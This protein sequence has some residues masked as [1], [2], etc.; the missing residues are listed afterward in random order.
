M[1]IEYREES[2]MNVNRQHTFVKF[3]TT[4]YNKELQSFIN[5][6]KVKFYERIFLKKISCTLRMHNI[7][8]VLGQLRCG[9]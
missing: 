3:R 5:D 2:Y 7:G 1:Y 4:D 9:N 6:S 8:L